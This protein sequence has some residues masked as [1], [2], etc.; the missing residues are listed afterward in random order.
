MSKKQQEP[1]IE[2]PNSPHHHNA[3]RPPHKATPI[4]F[5]DS[6]ANP[7]IN[8]SSNSKESL[9]THFAKQALNPHN[10]LTSKDYKSQYI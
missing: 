8:T 9:R 7:Q 4:K 3:P 2:E 6:I 5:T 10:N 1:N